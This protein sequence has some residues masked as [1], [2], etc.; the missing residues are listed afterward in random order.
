MAKR[1]GLVVSA[2]RLYH[3][4][5]H[6]SRSVYVQKHAQDTGD[7]QLSAL[8][9]VVWSLLCLSGESEF[10]VR[11]GFPYLLGLVGQKPHQLDEMSKIFSP[12]FL[13]S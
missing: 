9:A 7:N 8:K 5:Q 3:L 12:N 10:W 4:Q 6:L 1:Q 11:P 2:S 13:V